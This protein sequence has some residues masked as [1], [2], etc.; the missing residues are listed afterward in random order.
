MSFAMEQPVY[1]FEKD[2][3]ELYVAL[4]VGKTNY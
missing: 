1:G 3:T 2:Y 4:E